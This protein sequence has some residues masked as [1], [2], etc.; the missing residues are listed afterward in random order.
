MFS[1]KEIIEKILANQKN[2]I[3]F[4]SNPS[5]EFVDYDTCGS[6][7]D[8]LGCVLFKDG[9]IYRGVYRKSKDNF[10]ELYNTGILQI[11]AEIGY[12]PKFK[13]T[14]YYTK[15]YPIIF[16]IEKLDIIPAIFWSF[17]MIK[18]EAKLKIQI[19][20]ILNEF[21]YTLIDGHTKNSTFK[22]GKPIFFDFGSVIKETD[23][24][25][26]FWEIITFNLIPL[27]M[28]ANGNYVTSRSLYL[29][30]VKPCSNYMKS[31][32]VESSLKKYTNWHNRKIIKKIRNLKQITCE[33]IDV[34][35]PEGCYKKETELKD[36]YS[37]KDI[38]NNPRFKIIIDKVKNYSSDAKTLLDIAGNTGVISHLFSQ[39]LN[40]NRIISAD[41]DEMAVEKGINLYKN[42][43]ITFM[44][45]N[46]I[47][48]RLPV[49][50]I[51]KSDIVLALALSHHI[52]LTQNI[53]I[54][55]MFKQLKKYTNKYLY[56]EFCPL[57][58]YSLSETELPQ[59]PQWYREDWFEEHFLKYFTLINKETIAT[60]KVNQ[61]IY[62]HR[63]LFVGKVK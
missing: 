36:Y 20:S 54:D 32:E 52:L 43:N 48:P 42:D 57:G 33:E 56:L 22:N 6:A 44:V 41:Y 3:K 18:E 10:I 31:Y 50:E 29:G 35:F 37:N 2:I 49:E 63:I 61:C 34:L 17:S 24:T 27:I 1:C 26:A 40:F 47:R 51:I 38:E 8:P 21:G 23:N 25:W 28:L 4:D 58:M 60:V 13:I 45:F 15:D 30:C 5:V 59:V 39:S 16:E 9:K 19:I 62:P 53:D 11:F 7:L 12:M 46:T 55:Y 14:D